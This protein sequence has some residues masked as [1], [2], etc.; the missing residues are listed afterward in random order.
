[1]KK[2]RR[3]GVKNTSKGHAEQ[4]ERRWQEVCADRERREKDGARSMKVE[5]YEV[6]VEIIRIDSGTLG[7]SRLLHWRLEGFG[8]FLGMTICRRSWR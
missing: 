2:D 7:S 5:M 8:T 3:W 1:M 6:I 4:E